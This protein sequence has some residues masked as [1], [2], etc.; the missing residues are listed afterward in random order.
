MLPSALPLASLARDFRLRA[1]FQW[2]LVCQSHPLTQVALTF[3]PKR[4]SIHGGRLE[5][6]LLVSAFITLKFLATCHVD[7]GLPIAAGAV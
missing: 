6:G 5:L 1:T 4:K 7:V 2:L 3:L